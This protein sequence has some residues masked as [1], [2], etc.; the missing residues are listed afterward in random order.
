MYVPDKFA[1]DGDSHAHDLIEDIRLGTVVSITANAARGPSGFEASHIPF[2][3]DRQRGE[4]GTLIGL[5]ARANPQWRSLDV[6]SSVLA[7]FL[8]PSAY[9]SPSHYASWPR[10]PTWTY[11]SVQAQGKVRLVT[12]AGDLKAMVMRLCREMEPPSTGWHAGNLPDTF[13][14]KLVRAIVGFEIEI[15]SLTGA[16]RLGQNNDLEDRRR[17]ADALSVGTS[18]DQIVGSLVRN[19]IRS[20][21]V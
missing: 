1:L 15:E 6:G 9:V 19:L 8:G 7:L 14:D 2:M 17:V 3:V 16:V 12:E 20:A 11:V 13:V 21:E 5:V 18:S 4:H 10:A